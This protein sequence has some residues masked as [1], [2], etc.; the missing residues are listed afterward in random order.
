[1]I[2]LMSE[3]AKIEVPVE[4]FC[5]YS[6]K[7]RELREEF[8]KHVAM[9][10][11]RNFIKVWHDQRILAGGDWKGEIDEHLNSADIIALFVSSDFL[12]SDYCY[13]K[14]MKQAMRRQ[15]QRDAFVVPVIV[16]SCDSSDAPFGH[17]QAIPT[18]ALPVTK[19][20]D[21]DEA[22]TDVAD[23]LKI[24]VMQVLQ[25]NMT[26]VKEQVKRELPGLDLK[27]I[28]DSYQDRNDF[29]NAMMLSMPADTEGQKRQMDRWEILQEEQ[30]KIFE[31]QQDVTANKAATQAAAYKRWEEYLRSA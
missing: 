29:E 4:I 19:W 16:R 23:R 21:R 30:K 2:A 15:E 17:L 7:D 18:D 25:R 3:P 6:H 14:E 31:I 27:K 20:K 22:W 12:A 13:E 1:M 5:S 10:K 9:M 11:R 26:K 8:E 28:F 24:T